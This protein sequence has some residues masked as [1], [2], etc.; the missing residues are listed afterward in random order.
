MKLSLIW[1]LS[2]VA[3]V[4]QAENG[5]PVVDI[6][7]TR[8]EAVFDARPGQ[9]LI[10]RPEDASRFDSS[11]LLKRDASITLPETGRVSASGFAVPR[12][13]GQDARLTEIYVEDELLQDP[14][15][16][17]PLV[18]ELDVRA[19]GELAYHIGTTPIDL[20]TTNPVGTL[21]YR[22]RPLTAPSLKV[23]S[24]IGQPY[25][26]AGWL[27][28]GSP[29]GATGIETRLYM[30]QHQ[31]SGHFAYHD[32]HGTPYNTDD[33]T[34]EIRSGNDRRSAQ[35][36]PQVSY[37]SGR[38]TARLFAVLGEGTAGLPGADRLHSARQTAHNQLV[39]MQVKQ[40]LGS[41]PLSSE[42]SLRIH[43]STR[44][45]ERRTNDP[46]HAILV[47]KGDAALKVDSRKGGATYTWDGERHALRVT[48]DDEH[49]NVLSTADHIT[50][51][52][53]R[54]E[55][56]SLYAGVDMRP[57][58]SSMLEVKG[59]ALVIADR[60]VK[61][62]GDWVLNAPTENQVT[63]KA[64]GTSVAASQRIGAADF[65]AQ[66]AR[67][68]RP[69]SLLEAFGDGGAVRGSPALTPETILHREIGTTVRT[70]A[71]HRQSLAIFQDD[72][73]NRIVLLPV[74]ANTL[75]AKN[76]ETTRI[77]GL[78]SRTDLVFENTR[79]SLGLTRLIPRNL[80]GQRN[81]V[82][83]SIAERYA[84]IGVEQDVAD[85][86]LRAASRYQSQVFRDTGNSIIVPAYAVH[87][88]G[89]DIHIS[90][91]KSRLDLGLSILNVTDVRRLEVKAP[92]SAKNKGATAFSDVDG[93][94]LPGRQWRLSVAASW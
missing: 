49:A 82:L 68:L 12:I 26:S 32:D 28:A 35:A 78:E 84:A 18:D 43:G 60:R 38:T 81:T 88:L 13:R 4:A 65:Y 11:A 31:T 17:L 37:K 50:E 8:P 9:S 58:P 89:A 44:D 21:R 1:L 93:Y 79:V 25:G 75:R 90:M 33:D 45:D 62:A 61:G 87:D 66:F 86:T 77:Q 34:T 48:A 19:F 83:P 74:L 71:G 15:S 53:V 22:L 69:P 80:T 5:P 39:S 57:T 64:Q 24:T 55:V 42:M 7:G 29:A 59:R 73:T 23:G 41:G 47:T 52:Q 70:A 3:T 36:L 63:T 6:V 67:H 85:V 14:Y 20:A 27:A 76:L 46:S 91:A 16:G 40:V 30:R 2:W 54:R 72:I 94:P 51:I 56:Q 92:G 10:F